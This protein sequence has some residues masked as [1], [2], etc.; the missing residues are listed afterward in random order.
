MPS[1]TQSGP[2]ARTFV[3]LAVLIVFVIAVNILADEFSNTL[4]LEIRPSNEDSIHRVLMTSALI[5]LVLLAI[6]FVPAVEIGMILIAVFGPAVAV[7]LYV[8]TVIGLSISF[9]VGRLVPLR[10]VSSIFREFHLRRASALLDRLEAMERDARLP[11]LLR[12]APG[13]FVPMLLRHRYLLLAVALNLPGNLLIGGGGG[14]ALTAGISKLYS[15]GGFLLTVA[16]AV[17][18]IPLAVLIVGKDLV[19]G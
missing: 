17:A 13:R 18:P 16:I 2:R 1:K 7:L 10:V 15:V 9:L 14:I 5:Y 8:C 19:T 3:K 11:F 4:Q 12:A 6:P